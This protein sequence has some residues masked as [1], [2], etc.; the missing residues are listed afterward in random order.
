MMDYGKIVTLNAS[1]KN[2]SDTN[3]AMPRNAPTTR[4]LAS[5]G[6]R[7]LSQTPMLT[8]RHTQMPRWSN[9][10]TVDFAATFFGYVPRSIGNRGKVTM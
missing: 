2:G 5:P 10:A 7:L 9:A 3:R 8:R 6:R 1:S 4:Y